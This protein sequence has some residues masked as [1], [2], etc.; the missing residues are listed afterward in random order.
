M[1]KLRHPEKTG[2][3][4]VTEWAGGCCDSKPSLMDARARE[5]SLEPHCHPHTLSQIFL[6]QQINLSPLGPEFASTALEHISVLSLATSPG[7][8]SHLFP[9]CWEKGWSFIFLNSLLPASSGSL[10]S[11]AWSLL[12]QLYSH[13]PHLIRLYS[14]WSSFLSWLC[15]STGKSPRFSQ[16]GDRGL[17]SRGWGWD[18]TGNGS[19]SYFSCTVGKSDDPVSDFCWDLKPK[20]MTCK[21]T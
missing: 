7:F 3:E 14:L 18:E 11:D 10:N 13:S 9:P 5:R 15:L 21:C 4:E 20:L 8:E 6:S 16:T 19:L 17:G 12:S 2:C 1:R